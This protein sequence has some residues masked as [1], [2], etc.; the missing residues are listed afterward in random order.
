MHNPEHALFVVQPS[1]GFNITIADNP[2][3]DSPCIT[4][5]GFDDPSFVFD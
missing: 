4:I 1:E 5:H 2:G 3:N